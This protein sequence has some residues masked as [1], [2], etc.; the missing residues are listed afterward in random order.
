M[1]QSLGNDIGGLFADE[2]DGD[3]A[4]TAMLVL[5]RNGLCGDEA[6]LSREY[7]ERMLELE[8][9][10]QEQSVWSKSL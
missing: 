4:S 5:R 7:R 10:R 8:E 9:L 3:K 1:E 2:E 6:M